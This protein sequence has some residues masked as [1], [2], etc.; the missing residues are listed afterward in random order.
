MNALS[1]D[2]PG[3]LRA[4]ADLEHE[5]DD[6]RAAEIAREMTH[7]ENRKRELEMSRYL[8][9]QVQWYVDALTLGD[10]VAKRRALDQV[11]ETVRQL[12]IVK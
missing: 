7:Y 1:N 6:T 8:V 3:W 2:C 4:M 9:H 10:Q 11:A 12:E 5:S